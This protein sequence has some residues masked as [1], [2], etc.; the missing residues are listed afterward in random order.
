M[1]HYDPYYEPSAFDTGR[2]EAAYGEEMKD[3]ARAAM[4]AACAEPGKLRS[5]WL[6]FCDECKEVSATEF[7]DGLKEIGHE[8][9]EDAVTEQWDDFAEA[10]Q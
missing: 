7:V 8:W 5:A 6:E 10:C 3:R 1:N 4:I 2:D 9:W